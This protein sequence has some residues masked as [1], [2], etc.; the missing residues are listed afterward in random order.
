MKIRPI[1]I[2]SILFIVFSVVSCL[3]I[4][5]EKDEKEIIIPDENFDTNTQNI[6]VPYA[7]SITFSNGQTIVNNPF[8]EHGISVNV[9]KQNVTITSTTLDIE[10]NYVLS[11]NT[12]NGFVKIYSDLR[13][14]LVL[15]GVSILNPTGAAINI[16]SGKRVS[17]TLVDKT[18]NRLI[19]GG[20]FQITDEERMDGTF[21]SQGQLI[22]NGAGSLLIYANDG[23][24]IGVR[25]YIQI[26]NGNITV[27]NATSDG[28]HCRDYFE[29]NGG[30][31]VI[32][33]KS[34]GIE[35][36]NQYIIVNGGTLKIKSG[37]RGL[38]SAG[39][40]TIAGGR[41]EIESLDDGIY[42]V[43]NVVINRGEIFNNS[44]KN[45]IV[46]TEGAIAI[47]GGLLVTSGKKNV[48]D[49][50]KTFSITGGI[51]IGTGVATVIPDASTSKQRTVVWG[52]SKFTAGQLIYIKS[53]NNAEVLTFKFPRAYTGNMTLVY[54]SPLLQA[55]NNYTIYKGGAVSGGSEFHGLYSG[56]VSSGGTVATTFYTSAMVTTVGK[57]NGL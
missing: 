11:G 23:H 39:N 34:D 35:S 17:V 40:L 3:K 29:M 31:V 38:K 50:V 6:T 9:D 48:F 22:F 28:I 32:N 2:I 45:A 43:N 20:T 57:V 26:N 4:P 54:A 18:N 36:T 21:H 52:A 46:S 8:E 1:V 27:N 16:Q 13:F 51:A 37:N 12:S 25:D 5:N 41:I 33:A 49:C 24:A 14:G 7:V 10:A 42:A 30:N 19:D 53:S 15:N 56:A 55:N 47:T 44:E